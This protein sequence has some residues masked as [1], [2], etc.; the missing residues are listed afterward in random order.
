[1]QIRIEELHKHAKPC[2][3]RQSGGGSAEGQQEKRYL[4]LS[5]PYTFS[6]LRPIPL[7]HSFYRC[8]LLFVA[9]FYDTR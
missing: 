6:H 4:N 9:L 3:D 5:L 7:F 8:S 1:M 2:P